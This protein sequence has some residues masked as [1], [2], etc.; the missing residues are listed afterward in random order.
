MT[1]GLTAAL[2]RRGCRGIGFKQRPGPWLFVG[3]AVDMSGPKDPGFVDPGALEEREDP[4]LV[5]VFWHGSCAKTK[6]TKLGEC[7]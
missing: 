3:T 2:T 7:D 6:C 1:P 5:F 4:G